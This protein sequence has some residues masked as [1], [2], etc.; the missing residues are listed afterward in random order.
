[1]GF[2]VGFHADKSLYIR[3]LVFNTLISKPIVSAKERGLKPFL[4]QNLCSRLKIL[5]V[6]NLMHTYLLEHKKSLNL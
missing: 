6:L 4:L 3:G 2:T 1:M 5:N